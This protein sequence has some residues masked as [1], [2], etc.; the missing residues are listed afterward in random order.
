MGLLSFYHYLHPSCCCSLFSYIEEV[1]LGDLSLYFI[2][3]NLGRGSGGA[4]MFL[5]DGHF[6]NSNLGGWFFLY[7]CHSIKCGPG[8]SL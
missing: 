6:I 2:N 5:Y 8:F 1:S 3:S 7:D 4:W